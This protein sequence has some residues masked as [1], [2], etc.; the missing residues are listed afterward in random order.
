MEKS[1]YLGK[2][3]DKNGYAVHLFYKYRGHEYMITDEHNGCSESMWAKHKYE[4]DRI[5]RIVD[6]DYETGSPFDAD[7]IFELLGWD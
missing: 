4:Q 5:D 7:E 2:V 3:R 1:E 6:M